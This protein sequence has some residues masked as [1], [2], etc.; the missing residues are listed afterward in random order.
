MRLSESRFGS[1]FMFTS[2]DAQT[3]W[4][5]PPAEL[6]LARDEVHV[7]RARLDQS[8]RL[9][10]FSATLAA[11]E[12]ARASR[13]RFQIDR[14]HFI[15]ARGLLRLLLSRYLCVSPADLSFRL[16]AYGKPSLAQAYDTGLCFNISH[17]HGLALLAFAQDRELG[18]DLEAVRPEVAGLSIAER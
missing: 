5:Q 14:E 18:V 13:Y 16:N 10:D 8:Q 15:A 2:E 1:L 12:K 11:D 17:S 7:W 9:A 3:I 4:Q 6:S